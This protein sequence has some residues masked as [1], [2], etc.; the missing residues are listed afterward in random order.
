MSTRDI[1]IEDSDFFMCE[2]FR[3]IATAS[4]AELER[5]LDVNGSTV[6]LAIARYLSGLPL[7]DFQNPA[8]MA[9]RIAEFCQ[10]PGCERLEEWW[11]DLYNQLDTDGIDAVLKTSLDPGE[12]ADDEPETQRTLTNEGRDI[13]QQLERWAKEVESQNHPGNQNASNSN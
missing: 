3:Q 9:N 12:E 8:V 7:T 10:K 4:D 5:Q 13:C 11:G 1:V 2:A 6:R